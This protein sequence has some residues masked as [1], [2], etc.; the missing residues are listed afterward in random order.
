[1]SFIFNDSVNLSQLS[2][3]GVSVC[4]HVFSAQQ[5]GK[6]E[7]KER[8]TGLNPYA[9]ADCHTSAHGL[10]LPFNC[11]TERAAGIKVLCKTSGK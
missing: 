7:N 9:M 1:M 8:E 11:R 10:P 6:G 5:N 4:V 2:P 3:L